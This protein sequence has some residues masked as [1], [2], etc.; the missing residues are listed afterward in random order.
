MHVRIMRT[1]E[2]CS[3]VVGLVAVSTGAGVSMVYNPLWGLGDSKRGILEEPE[4]QA[5]GE[6]RQ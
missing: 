6:N 2:S 1:L 5:E 3:N 4:I